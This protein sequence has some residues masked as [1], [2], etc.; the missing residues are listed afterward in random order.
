MFSLDVGKFQFLPL[1]ILSGLCGL[2]TPNTGIPHI[3]VITGRSPTLHSEGYRKG[4]H[5]ATTA[6][7]D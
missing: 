3:L 7:G 5:P 4:T 1:F 6:T 2:Y